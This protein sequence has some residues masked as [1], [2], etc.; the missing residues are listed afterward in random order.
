MVGLSACSCITQY[1]LIGY[2]GRSN[3][4]F[5][6]RNFII[7]VRRRTSGMAHTATTVNVLVHVVCIVFLKKIIRWKR[8]VFNFGG[9]I[10]ILPILF[11][12][13][14]GDQFNYCV[15]QKRAKTVNTPTHGEGRH[16]SPKSRREQRITRASGPG[17]TV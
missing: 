16:D 15:N 2:F 7:Q 8:G 10:R 13:D 9:K 6:R 1:L 3:I 5:L 17:K 4:N 14:S 11:F 12:V